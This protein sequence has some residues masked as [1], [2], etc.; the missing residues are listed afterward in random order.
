MHTMCALKRPPYL[1]AICDLALQH[2]LNSTMK[3]YH[4][5]SRKAATSAGCR[6]KSS[7]E[8]AAP[9]RRLAMLQPKL[10][11]CPTRSSVISLSAAST[12]GFMC[13]FG[14][15]TLASSCCITCIAS[16]VSQTH[17][18]RF[19]NLDCTCFTLIR[20]LLIITAMFDCYPQQLCLLRG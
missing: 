17:R 13:S 1:Q 10:R 4:V 6:V 3:A 2:Q 9:C 7:A 20:E 5:C 18:N 15:P 12:S 19:C 14:P 8:A 11:A 16:G